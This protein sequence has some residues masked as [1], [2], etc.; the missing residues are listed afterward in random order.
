MLSNQILYHIVLVFSMSVA[1]LFAER[2]DSPKQATPAQIAKLLGQAK[3]VGIFCGDDVDSQT[4]KFF[5]NALRVGLKNE[6]VTVNLFYQPETL[7]QSFYVPPML[8]P[9]TDVTVRLIEASSG[10]HGAVQV[11]LGG[12]CYD[13][14]SQDQ[15][16]FQLPRW[17]ETESARDIGPI[18]ADKAEAASKLAKE[19]STYWISTVKEKH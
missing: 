11:H 9:F 6:H 3:L 14:H 15:L 5:V 18:E 12:T 10:P 4:C 2:R 16:G 7:V 1:C 8:L 19:F 13:S 17:I